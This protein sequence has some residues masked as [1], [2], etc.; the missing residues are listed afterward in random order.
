MAK[1]VVQSKFERGDRVPS[2]KQR[3]VRTVGRV[4]KRGM[5]VGRCIDAVCIALLNT[6]GCK[7]LTSVGRPSHQGTSHHQTNHEIT[8]LWAGFEDKL[9]NNGKNFTYTHHM[10]KQMGSARVREATAEGRAC[11]T[12]DATAVPYEWPTRCAPPLLFLSQLLAVLPA[13]H[14]PLSL[15][16]LGVLLS[17]PPQPCLSRMASTSSL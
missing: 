4:G 12:A 17:Q 16:L 9:D 15:S 7:G 10:W 3:G 13:V 11:S 1:C 2:W 8:Q 5:A 6:T 14:V